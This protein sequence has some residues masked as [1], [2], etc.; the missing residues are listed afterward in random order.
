MVSYRCEGCQK[1]IENGENY[2]SMGGN[3]VPYIPAKWY[4][5]RCIP[6]INPAEYTAHTLRAD[7][8]E[9]QFCEECPE[10]ATFVVARDGVSHFYCEDHGTSQNLT[11]GILV[12]HAEP[13][14]RCAECQDPLEDGHICQKCAAEKLL[15][16]NARLIKDFVESPEAV[17]FLSRAGYRLNIEEINRLLN[18]SGLAPYSSNPAPKP[19]TFAPKRFSVEWF[20]AHVDHFIISFMVGVPLLVANAFASNI[21][22]HHAAQILYALGVPAAVRHWMGY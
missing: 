8:Y 1:P 18:E 12:N 14:S 2:A 4:H 6:V 16:E 7:D 20:K 13:E 21:F 5:V 22:S 3:I 19:F 10:P 9:F 17:D 15:H 11:R